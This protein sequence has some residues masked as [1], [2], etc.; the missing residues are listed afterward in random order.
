MGIRLYHI[1]I[2][3]PAAL[4]LNLVVLVV[5]GTTLVEPTQLVPQVFQ[6]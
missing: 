1:I 2:A 5:T 4:Y 6:G 3:A